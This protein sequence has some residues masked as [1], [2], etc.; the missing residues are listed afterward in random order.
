MKKVTLPRDYPELEQPHNPADPDPW[1]T[2]WLDNSAPI[3]AGVKKAWLY[4]SNT[5]SRQFLLPIVRPIARM[6]IV[7]LQVIKVIIPNWL[8]SSPILHKFLAWALSVFATPEANWL[9]LRHFWI[10]SENLAFL[11][12][13]IQHGGVE[14]NPLTPEDL[15]DLVDDLFIKHDLNLFNFITRLNQK[16][17]SKGTTEVRAKK[18]LDFSMIS[19]HGDFPIKPQNNGLLNVVDLQTCIDLFTPM[20]QLFLTDKDFWRSVHSL[21]LDET[22]GIYAAKVLNNP[23]ALILLNNKHP[24]VIPATWS[25]GYRLV[26]HGLS[27]EML[28]GLIVQEKQRNQKTYAQ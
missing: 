28:H 15:P 7:L 3:K 11:N 13:N 12:A 21:Q 10:G 20:Y 19:D 6:M 23:E 8:T 16:I 5:W 26:L 25:A 17:Q 18:T 1:Q 24:M 14:M 9:I 22:I 4:D 2:L 27:A